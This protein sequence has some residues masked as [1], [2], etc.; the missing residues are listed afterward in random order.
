LES[1]S[2]VVPL[3]DNQGK[4]FEE[5][6]IHKIKGKIIDRFSGMTAVNVVG[7]WK[8][9]QQVFEDKNIMLLIDVPSKDSAETSEYFLN[10]KL[11]L[12]KELAQEKIYVTKV[13]EKSE[14]ITANEFLQ[15]L[16][17]EVPSDQPQAFSQA[18]IEK[19]VSKSE[20][21]KNRLT[22]KTIRTAWGTGIDLLT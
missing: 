9:G 13:G 6:V 18:N 4:A 19:L 7:S 3:H 17:F 22:Y 5:E 10:L 15:E 12:M 11:E 20:I 16:G 14:L 1:W 8:G 2:L 21:A